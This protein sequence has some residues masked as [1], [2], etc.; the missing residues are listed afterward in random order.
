[1]VLG[2]RVATR[3]HRIWSEYGQELYKELKKLPCGMDVPSVPRL[4]PKIHPDPDQDKAGW[5]NEELEEPKQNLLALALALTLFD[6]FNSCRFLQIC[7]SFPQS[8]HFLYKLPSSWETENKESLCRARKYTKWKSLRTKDPTSWLFPSKFL[9]VFARN[10]I[11]L[12]RTMF[13]FIK[14][15]K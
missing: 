14:G 4:D 2:Q 8:V 9:H 10:Q 13:Y 11:T 3:M 7:N 1:M 5:M 12:T 15:A 6:N